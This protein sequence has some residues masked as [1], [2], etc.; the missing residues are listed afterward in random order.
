M[1]NDP[2]VLSALCG[3][4]AEVVLRAIAHDN[5]DLFGEIED[6][7]R[8]RRCRSEWTG[9]G[10][11]CLTASAILIPMMS[12]SGGEDRVKFYFH[13]RLVLGAEIG[14]VLRDVANVKLSRGR[15]FSTA[16][17]PGSEKS[18]IDYVMP[19]APRILSHDFPSDSGRAF[20]QVHMKVRRA[21]YMICAHLVEYGRAGLLAERAKVRAAKAK[22]LKSKDDSSLLSPKSWR[23]ER[24]EKTLA[25]DRHNDLWEDIGWRG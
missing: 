1:E 15:N 13:L 17:F 23:A 5:Q 16:H 9:N 24:R 8:M 4:P 21:V 22:C 3:G 6:A 14:V 7:Q 19:I 10:H 18:N 20:D 25:G 2:V 11:G 12:I